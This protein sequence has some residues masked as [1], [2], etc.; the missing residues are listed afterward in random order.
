ML[1]KCCEHSD[2]HTL[3]AVL[4]LR[5]RFRKEA[6]SCLHCASRD[7]TQERMVEIKARSRFSARFISCRFIEQ[8]VTYVIPF[9][10]LRKK[11]TRITLDRRTN[12][13][14][15]RVR[16]RTAICE[17]CTNFVTLAS[18]FLEKQ[19]SDCKLMNNHVLALRS[20]AS[21]RREPR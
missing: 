14:F 16:R 19:T 7:D 13:I 2:F 11:A 9:H 10:V 12:E 3:A 17:K 1:V 18:Y 8:L 15:V 20:Y 4:S 5:A 6:T 21:E